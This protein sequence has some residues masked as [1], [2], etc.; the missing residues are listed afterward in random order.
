MCVLFTN[1]I[2]IH[3]LKGFL[4]ESNNKGGRFIDNWNHKLRVDI[5]VFSHCHLD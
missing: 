2:R 5:S 4:E 1:G 3:S